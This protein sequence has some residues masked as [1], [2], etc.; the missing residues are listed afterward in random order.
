MAGVPKN[1]MLANV[2]ATQGQINVYN[3]AFKVQ[4]LQL[5]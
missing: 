4:R 2:T 3:M 5:A 1:M